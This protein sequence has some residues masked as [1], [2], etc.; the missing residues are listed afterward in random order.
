MGS[1]GGLPER[2]SKA[3]ERRFPSLIDYRVASEETSSHNCIAYA[4]GDYSRK[5]DPDPFY[6]WPP[7]AKRGRDPDSLKS[8]FE[9]IGYE[10]CIG[11]EL[12]PGYEKVAL[13]VDNQ[14][15]WQHA[16]KQEPNGE[17]SSKLGNWEDIRHRSP[18]CFGGSD[19]G[20]VI[21]FMKRRIVGVQDEGS[22]AIQE[23]AEEEE[24]E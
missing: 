11:G 2:L 15:L 16:A 23:A 12:E 8:A 3:R 20:V 17:W 14:G 4:A 5:W 19:Y 18:H 7:N 13:Y 6:Y 9:A 22:K 21:Y 24:E 10:Q 1:E